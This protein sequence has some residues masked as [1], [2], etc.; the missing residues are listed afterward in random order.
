MRRPRPKLEFCSTDKKVSAY[1][2]LNIF[3]INVLDI[4]NSFIITVAF[5]VSTGPTKVYIYKHWSRIEVV[6]SS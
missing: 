3:E 5:M 2:F 4:R 1:N 6:N